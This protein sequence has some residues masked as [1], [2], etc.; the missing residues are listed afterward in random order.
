MKLTGSVG[1][2]NNRTSEAFKMSE[3]IQQI[4]T[5]GLS[6]LLKYVENRVSDS[7]FAAATLLFCLFLTPS[8]IVGLYQGLILNARR[9]SQADFV[10]PVGDQ[11]PRTLGH[12]F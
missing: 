8:Q 3:A 4:A 10:V 6:G 9:Q 12:R 1:S 11:V 5:S 7:F 2:P